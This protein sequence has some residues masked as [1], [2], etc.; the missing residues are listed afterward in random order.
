MLPD[1]RPLPR[2]LLITG[3]VGVGKT[4]VAEAMG[5][6]LVNAQIPGAVMDLDWLRQSW[7][8]P[9]ADR[10]NTGMLLQNLRCVAGNYLAAGATRLVLA[11]VAE[12][13][14]DRDHYEEAVGI[15]LSVCR[16]RVHLPTVHQRLA[17]R[18]GDDHDGLRW[19][20]N[21]S[22]ELDRILDHAKVE[23]FT[24]DGNDN[25]ITATAM[26]VLQTANWL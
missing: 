17:H 1:A 13:R 22:G 25:S 8:T 15:D 2:A 10:F 18:H 24:I 16:L 7:P 14:A 4:S 20:L 3:T 9:T 26:A 19:H 23:D 11:G 12:S 21:R 5:A 6:L